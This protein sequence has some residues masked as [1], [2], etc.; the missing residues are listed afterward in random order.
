VPEGDTIFRVARTLKGALAGKTVVRVSSSLPAV[1]A[2]ARRF[3]LVGQSVAAVEPRGKHL[4]MRF[5]GGSVLHTHMRM[6]GSWH[7]YPTGTTWRRPAWMARAVL[8]TAEVQAVCFAAPVVELLSPREAARHPSLASLGQD[9]LAAD[10]DAARTRAALRA[11]GRAEIAVALLDQTALAGIG[12]VYKSEV[13]FL[14]GVNPFARV[15]T[16]ADE[17]LDRLVGTARA[18]MQRNL[19]P[20]GRRTTSA[21]ANDR[22]WVYRWGGRPCRHCGTTVRRRLQG[23]QARSTYWCPRCQPA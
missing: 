22:Y 3:R 16:L 9:V 23:E 8:E 11:R 10:F 14:C 5:S 17:T 1:T 15:E 6:T 20:G 12:N 13:L 18:Q 21:L 2:A 19:G 7:L 4:L